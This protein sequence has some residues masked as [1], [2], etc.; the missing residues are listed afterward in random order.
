VTG[1]RGWPAPGGLPPSP[2][3]FYQQNDFD[4]GLVPWIWMEVTHTTG[5]L[6]GGT[7]FRDPA[8][9]FT[10]VVIGKI[11]PDGSYDP[12]TKAVQVPL[13]TRTYTAAQLGAAG[14]TTTGDINNFQVTADR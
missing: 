3:R 11:N 5:T 6:T 14:L 13:G 2:W 8:S 7:S 9:P 1:P 4:T 10:K 12:A